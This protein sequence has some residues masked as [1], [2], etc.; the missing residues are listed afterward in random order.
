MDIASSFIL[1]FLG[2]AEYPGSYCC[3]NKTNIN[4]HTHHTMPFSDK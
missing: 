1:D 2:G 3:N 4:L